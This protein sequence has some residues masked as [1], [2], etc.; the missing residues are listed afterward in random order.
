MA[1]VLRA[2][3]GGGYIFSKS[4]W[5]YFQNFSGQG[6]YPLPLLFPTPAIEGGKMKNELRSFKIFRRGN[7]WETRINLDNPNKSSN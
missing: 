1:A 5:G 4:S 2:A 7:V 3:E 6:V